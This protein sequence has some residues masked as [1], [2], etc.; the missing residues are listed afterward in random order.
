MYE[1]NA[2]HGQKQRNCSL[3][4]NSYFERIIFT[5]KVCFFELKARQHIH[6]H[7]MHSICVVSQANILT[8]SLLGTVPWT[9]HRTSTKNYRFEPFSSLTQRRKVK[10][11]PHF[12]RKIIFLAHD[13]YCIACVPLWQSTS[14]H[15]V[16]KKVFTIR[17]NRVGCINIYSIA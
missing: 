9:V 6:T 8:L 5:W 11:S 15:L 16:P 3:S 7:E 13:V 10:I 14:T 17:F 12:S 2:S 4:L 1:A